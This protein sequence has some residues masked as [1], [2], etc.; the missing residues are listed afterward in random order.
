MRVRSVHGRD[1]IYRADSDVGFLMKILDDMTEYAD[2]V[3]GEMELC[4]VCDSLDDTLSCRGCP[5]GE[6][7][8]LVALNN[9]G[10]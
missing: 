10:Q 8:R 2:W 7:M 5:F 3:L 1:I 9:S 4:E 6:L